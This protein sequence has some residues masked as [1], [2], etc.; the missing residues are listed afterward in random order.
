MRKVRQ[1]KRWAAWK[2]RTF[3]I[4]IIRFKKKTINWEA[5]IKDN[6]GL[7]NIRAHQLSS[8]I[9]E[10]PISEICASQCRIKEKNTISR[11]KD[12][13][14]LSQAIVHRWTGRTAILRHAKTWAIFVALHD[15]F[16]FIPYFKILKCN[17]SFLFSGVSFQVKKKKFF[18][19][20]DTWIK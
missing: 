4:P 11:P 16:I 6:L 12:K 14:I 17:F 2:V 19:I 7:P 5:K 3:N 8:K 20:S 13:K 15:I 1:N 18:Y 10:R 9:N